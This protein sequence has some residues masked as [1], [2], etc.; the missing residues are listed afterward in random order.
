MVV[1]LV[2]LVQNQT[3]LAA[4]SSPLRTSFP[5][6]RRVWELCL[7]FLPGDCGGAEQPG[8]GK[9]MHLLLVMQNILQYPGI[10]GESHAPPM[11]WLCSGSN[12]AFYA[13]TVLHI[14]IRETS[15]QRLLGRLC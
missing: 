9:A 15:E 4:S 12:R 5:A 14:R 1:V 7:L 11:K 6:R 8:Q 3:K 10:W 13:L 2:V